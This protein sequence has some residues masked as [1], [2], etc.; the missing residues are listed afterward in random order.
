LSAIIKYCTLSS[1]ITHHIILN[2]FVHCFILISLFDYFHPARVVILLFPALAV[3]FF[4]LGKIVSQQCS[5][6]SLQIS[7]FRVSVYLYVL[8]WL[9]WFLF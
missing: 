2:N 1:G 9:G 8:L 6:G 5:A 4:N 7:Q 3:S